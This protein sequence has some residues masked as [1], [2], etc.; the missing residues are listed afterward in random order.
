[1][2]TKWMAGKFLGV[3]VVIASVVAWCGCARRNAP[4]LA[5]AHATV[6]DASGWP[7]QTDSTVIIS[8][9]RIISVGPS[10]SAA[11]P[12]GAEII[13]ARGIFLI[14]GFADMHV[15][16]T[17]AGGLAAAKQ[18]ILPLLI[19]NGVTS[20][21]DMGGYLETLIPL[22]QEIEKGEVFG[23]R[24]YFAG[25]YLD[26]S[27]PSFEPSLVVTNAVEAAE[28]VHTLVARNVNFIKV[29][30]ILNRE[31]YFAIAAAARREKISF[32]GHVPDRVTAGEA[33]ES[34][35][36][37]VEHLT[38]VLRGCT[39]D[40]PHLMGL[41]LLVTPQPQTVEQ[42]QRR[43]RA[44]EH[45]LLR[46]YSEAHAGAL[47]E[48]FRKNRT[49]QVP[50][51]VLLRNDAYPSAQ[52]NAPTAARPLPELQYVP[53]KILG[54]WNQEMDKR[55]KRSSAEV[56]SLRRELLAKSMEVVGRM[57]GAG[58]PLLAGTDSGAPY[59]LFGSGL[60]QELKLLVQAGLTPMQA[61]QTATVNPARFLAESAIADGGTA[62]AGER[63]SGRGTGFENA[64]DESV[65]ARES[66]IASGKIADLVLLEGSPL[67][68]IRNTG[69]ISAVILRGTFLGRA[70]LDDLLAT[71]K[72][73]AALN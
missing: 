19:A 39:S 45:E 53:R 9:Q 14:P 47:F 63:M 54:G 64:K 22:R 59:V 37:S 35:Q 68:D 36:K 55:E 17:G 13:D 1:M 32:A 70:T 24:I 38:G 62:G 2:T 4:V 18:Y 69:K 30:S 25:P 56:Y 50:T 27:P 48:K 5:I 73:F 71:A 72:K 65:A 26:G 51:L 10:S 6:I 12:R 61:L 29:Q 58:V 40:E 49:W 42:S 66:L 31:A 20:V 67:E 28:D 7:P 21:R 3:A 16:L 15:H 23:P 52:L 33:S 41:Q 11:V 44:W 46:T 34:G 60:H 57:N 8:G 43:Q